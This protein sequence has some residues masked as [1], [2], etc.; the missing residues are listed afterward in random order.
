MKKLLKKISKNKVKKKYV[1]CKI[2]FFLA[3]IDFFFKNLIKVLKS[4]TNISDGYFLVIIESKKILAFFRKFSLS[5]DQS[6]EISYKYP[7][8]DQ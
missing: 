7:K 3:I 8:F 4:N 2:F 1:Q 6:C 5:I